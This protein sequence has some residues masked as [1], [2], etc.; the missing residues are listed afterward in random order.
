MLSAAQAVASRRCRSVELFDDEA[1]ADG[2]GLRPGQG[3]YLRG[4]EQWSVEVHGQV[5]LC[6]PEELFEQIVE[7]LS[8]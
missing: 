8:G 6:L 2:E 7:S 4:V 5:T 1:V 3:F